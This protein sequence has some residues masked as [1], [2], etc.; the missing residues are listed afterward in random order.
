MTAEESERVRPIVVARVRPRWP[1]E[2]DARLPVL[3]RVKSEA[4]GTDSVEIEPGPDGGMDRGPRAVQVT[5]ALGGEATQED[6]WGLFSGYLADFL[7]RINLSIFA[8]GETG[9]GKT[10]T[11][12][13]VTRRFLAELLSRR[14]D[15]D[16]F[17]V[18]I[19]MVEID[20]EKIYCLLSE[21]RRP[22]SIMNYH[23]KGARR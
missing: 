10:Y 13:Y 20:N 18:S 22:L 12:S 7:N 1:K 8:Y 6:V 19:S 4:D 14:A 9:S 2:T 16:R 23:V 21:E 11:M 3:V 5:H 15:Y 17:E